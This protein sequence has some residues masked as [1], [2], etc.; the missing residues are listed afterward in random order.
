MLFA[1]VLL[2]PVL[3]VPVTS[4]RRVVNLDARWQIPNHPALRPNATMHIEQLIF[5][6]RGEGS[7]YVLLEHSR[8]HILFGTLSKHHR[9]VFAFD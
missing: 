4:Y 1:K 9:T 7:R 5:K 8:A 6:H 2:L 3:S